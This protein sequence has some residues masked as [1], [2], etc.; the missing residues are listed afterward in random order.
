MD[1]R[2]KDMVRRSDSILTVAYIK[3][4]GLEVLCL[5]GKIKR[6]LFGRRLYSRVLSQKTVIFILA[7]MRTR[8]LTQVKT[9]REEL[10]MFILSPNS[11]FINISGFG[12]ETGYPD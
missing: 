10:F 1:F 12:Q 8:N 6:K 2:S 3:Y 4:Q 5:K 7:A 11:R 9:R